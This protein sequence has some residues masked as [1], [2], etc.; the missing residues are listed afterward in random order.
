[1]RS[2]PIAAARARGQAKIRTPG[3]ALT[4]GAR[5]CSKRRVPTVWSSLALALVALGAAAAAGFTPPQAEELRTVKHLYVATRRAD[6]T[7]GR[8]APVWFMVDGDA[9]LFTTAPDS[10]K[11]RRIRRG[12]PLEV[13]IGRPDGPHFVGRA[14]LLQDPA[15]A[16]RMAPVYAAKYWIAWAGLFRPNPERVR[17]GKT[18]IVRVTPEG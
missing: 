5:S 3:A 17:R 14:E 2:G 4:S 9:L 7:L 11:A 18:T 13:W 8:P 10:H 16:A 12:S 1:M 6:G 15:V